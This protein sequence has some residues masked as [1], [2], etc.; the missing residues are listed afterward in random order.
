[1]SATLSNPDRLKSRSCRQRARLTG[2]SLGRSHGRRS[3]APAAGVVT[4]QS[5]LRRAKPCRDRAQT[6][7]GREYARISRNRRSR[8]PRTPQ[9]AVEGMGKVRLSS[10]RLRRP[11][12]ERHLDVAAHAGG[13]ERE[14]GAAVELVGDA[15]LDQGPR[16]RAAR[17]AQPAG[18][19]ARSSPGSG[20]P[21]RSR[22]ASPRRSPPA[23][24]H[25]ERA[26]FGGIGRQL[27]Q[28]QAER[29]R[30]LRRQGHVR[31]AQ[32]QI[33]LRAKRFERSLDQHADRRLASCPRRA[34]W[35]PWTMPQAAP[36][37]RVWIPPD[38]SHGSRF[39]MRSTVPRR[40]CSSCDG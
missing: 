7:C 2:G 19:R 32:P 38:R 24:R 6:P 5:R 30:H 31:A 28:H 36:R 34:A 13:R 29:Q 27:V 8:N 23:R 37:R 14:L 22:P 25:R 20:E 18:R 26:V 17:A 40:S 1:M 35:T 9:C 4:P 16:S 39:G 3:A 11:G 12:A 33:A 21:R 10:L 15:A